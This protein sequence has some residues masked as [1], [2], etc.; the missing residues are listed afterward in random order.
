MYN[1]ER[2]K[3][4]E[5]AIFLKLFVRALKQKSHLNENSASRP[6]MGEIDRCPN[7]ESSQVESGS[8]VESVR[9]EK[10]KSSIIWSSSALILD[11]RE[12][13]K[14]YSEFLMITSQL[15]QVISSKTLF[16]LE[17]P[18]ILSETWP[19]EGICKMSGEVLNG[20]VIQNFLILKKVEIE[21]WLTEITFPSLLETE[22]RLKP[23][24]H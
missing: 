7:I 2:R 11:S 13:N 14:F 22:S 19:V 1:F 23:S 4:Q 17:N 18:V 8:V 21:L 6:A 20:R 24:P 3:K 10:I 5:L 9:F 12:N 16:Y 15:W